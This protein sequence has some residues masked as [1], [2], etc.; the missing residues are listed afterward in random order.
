MNLAGRL[1]ILEFD[2]SGAEQGVAPQ[3]AALVHDLHLSH[4]AFED[5]EAGFVLP[6]ERDA[7]GE[8]VLR[9]VGL[10]YDGAAVLEGGLLWVRKLDSVNKNKLELDFNAKKQKVT[11]HN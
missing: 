8:V 1:Q 7:D 6:V 10:L 3:E 2:L 11:E 4:A 5:P 9:V